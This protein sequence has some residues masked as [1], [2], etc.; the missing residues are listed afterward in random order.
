MLMAKSRSAEEWKAVVSAISTI[1]EEAT[2]EATS[3]GISFRGMDPSHV[4][5]IDVQLL[6][7]AF[8]H[9]MCD[10]SIRFAV[11]VDEFLKLLKRAGKDD[12]IEISIGYAGT[13]SRRK[14]EVGER[15]RERE[16]VEAVEE[17]SMEEGEKGETVAITTDES[18][19]SIKMVG[20]YTRQYK[21]RLIE[22]TSSS[23]P[24]P[25]ITFNT[26]VVMSM[27]QFVEAL[28][29]VE[30]VSDYITMRCDGSTL[31]FIGKGDSGDA[32]IAFN[33][34]DE[35]VEEMISNGE[36]SATYSLEYLGSVVK[37]VDNAESVVVE[38]STRMPLRLEFKMPYMCR[39]YF[40]LAPRVEG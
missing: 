8:E 16:E 37:A 23:T 13:E 19:L 1:V 4:A 12:S 38:Y 9:Y 17:G 31:Q 3:E 25:K 18:M 6:N 2:F 5:L 30:I 15:E 20:K 34:G 24:L 7:S 27:S 28:K 32:M 36:S 26:R 14:G 29:D 40:Y 11:R 33:K 39:I 22:S 10:G 21:M 35:G